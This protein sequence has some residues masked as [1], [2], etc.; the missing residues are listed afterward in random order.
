MVV[1]Y[2]CV[3][4]WKIL[5]IT[6][7][8]RYSL[9]CMYLVQRRSPSKAEPCA[10]QLPSGSWVCEVGWG[11]CLCLP[12]MAYYGNNKPFTVWVEGFPCSPLS[13]SLVKISKWPFHW[14]HMCGEISRF[15]QNRICVSAHKAPSRGPPGFLASLLLWASTFWLVEQVLCFIKR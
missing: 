6:R 8:F 10:S 13:P 14:A 1:L 2:L 7:G 3:G 4:V 11:T 12:T 15:A 9:Q 5:F